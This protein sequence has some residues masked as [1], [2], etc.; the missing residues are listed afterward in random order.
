MADILDQADEAAEAFHRAALAA[1]KPEGPA[2]TGRCHA[3]DAPLVNGS[4]WCDADCRADWEY[5]QARGGC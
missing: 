3:C 1:K 4:R 2:P 5:E